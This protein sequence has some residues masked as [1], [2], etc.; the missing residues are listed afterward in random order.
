MTFSLRDLL[1]LFV[2]LALALLGWRTSQQARQEKARLVEL[3]KE[4]EKLEVCMR[5][6]RPDLHQ[7]MLNTLDEMQP[8]AEMRQRALAQLD[9]LRSRYGGLEPRG[10]D[11]LS[12]RGLPSLPEGEEPAPI[13]FRLLVPEQR[14]LW[15]KFGVHAAQQFRHSS[16]NPEDERE[17]LPRSPFT[18]SGP[19]EMRLPSG[20]QTLRITIGTARDGELPVTISL[21][22]GVLL[23]TTFVSAGTSGTGYSH[24]SAGSQLDYRASQKPPWL[25]TAIMDQRE[26]PSG[27]THAFSVWLD[28]RES[29]FLP[30]PRAPR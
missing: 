25:L 22:D 29:D 1:A 13:L 8:L 10:A 21:N 7:A 17:L 14:P 16:R 27:N 20:D 18:I 30:F 28:E 15:L 12:L 9:L 23:R 5:L 24:I 26:Q 2:L 3:R 6:D 4:I 11:V 19:F